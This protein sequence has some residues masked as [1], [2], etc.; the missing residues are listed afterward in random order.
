MI[1]LEEANEQIELKKK[2]PK[3]LF[4][5]CFSTWQTNI[6]FNNLMLILFVLLTKKVRMQLEKKKT[7]YKGIIGNV[8]KQFS[9][10]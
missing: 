8:N 2:N 4:V 7:S 3:R 5:V 6:L 9:D 1:M 10:R